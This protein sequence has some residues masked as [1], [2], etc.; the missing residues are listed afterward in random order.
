LDAYRFIG[1]G[2]K[3]PYGTRFARDILASFH[4]VGGAVFSVT[5]GMDSEKQKQ[6]NGTRFAR[7]F[8]KA[9]THDSQH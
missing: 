7:V 8:S 1:R 4:S 2:Q 6:L 9:K 5:G 3:Q